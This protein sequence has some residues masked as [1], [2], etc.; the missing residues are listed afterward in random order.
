MEKMQ[1]VQTKPRDLAEGCA[2]A[3]SL[4]HDMEHDPPANELSRVARYTCS[5]CGR[6]V[7]ANGGTVYGSALEVECKKL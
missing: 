5:K 2:Q 6:A 4:G 1:Q 7:L 3:K